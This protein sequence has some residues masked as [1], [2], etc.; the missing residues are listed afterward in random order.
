MISKLPTA[1]NNVDQSVSLV[2]AP[3]PVPPLP[4]LSATTLIFQPALKNHLIVLALVN[5][6]D[7][8]TTC[9][10]DQALEALAAS[11]ADEVVKAVAD[12]EPPATSAANDAKS[13]SNAEIAAIV[14]PADLAVVEVKESFVWFAILSIAVNSVFHCV[15]VIVLSLSLIHI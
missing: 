5:V 6:T 7:T 14:S 11:N 9:D 1:A 2:V 13:A 8:S 3:P 4:V 10:C 15:A 12:V